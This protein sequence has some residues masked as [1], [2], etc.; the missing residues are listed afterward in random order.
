MSPSTPPTGTLAA[1]PLI[2]AASVPQPAPAPAR[3]QLVTAAP[4]APVGR[5]FEPNEVDQAP[6]VEARVEPQLPSDLTGRGGTDAVVVR[7][8]VSHT[9]RPFRINLLRRSKFGSQVD[10]RVIAAVRQW[11]FQPAFKRGEPVSC[12][13][14]VGVL[15]KGD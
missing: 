5:L 10:D 4:D 14:H 13:L 6:R 7:I 9:G 3:A 1:S 12:W 8:L 11:T 15:L 2:A